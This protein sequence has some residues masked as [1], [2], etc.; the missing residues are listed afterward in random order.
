MTDDPVGQREPFAG[1]RHVIREWQT[2]AQLAA[3]L[4]QVTGSRTLVDEA[5]MEALLV[6]NRCLINFLCGNWKGR[7]QGN[8]MRPSDFLGYDWTPPD[9]L[10]ERRLRGRLGVINK[11]LAH[12]SWDRVTDQT[13]VFWSVVH[14]SH[15]TH[16]ALKLFTAELARTHSPVSG[17]FMACESELDDVLPVPK[18][19]RETRPVLAPERQE[20]HE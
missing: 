15:Q 11:Q 5:L 6:H 12:L 3:E 4:A 10:F 7:Y 2:M 13:P 9:A 16:V 17:V 20:R 1:A 19:V 8:D 18:Q 14:M